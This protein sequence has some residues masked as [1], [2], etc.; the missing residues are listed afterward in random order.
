MH[1][2]KGKYCSKTLLFLLIHTQTMSN[3][4]VLQVM[5]PGV[6]DL[7]SLKR[8]SCENKRPKIKTEGSAAFPGVYYTANGLP[9]AWVQVPALPPT[10]FVCVKVTA[11]PSLPHL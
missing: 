7:F 2:V 3:I 6:V 8:I 4:N 9:S 10:R 1:I 11:L 5:V